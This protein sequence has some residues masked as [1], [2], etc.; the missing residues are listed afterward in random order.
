MAKKLKY[1]DLE[2]EIKAGIIHPVYF[3]VEEESFLKSKAI[4][5]V[6]KSLM[7]RGQEPFN[8]SVFYGEETGAVAVLESLQTPPLGAQKRLAILRNFQNMSPQDKQKIVEYAEHPITSAV[9]I[10]ELGKRLDLSSRIY[11]RLKKVAAT[12][13]FYHP[14]NNTD[15]IRFLQ[16]EAIA[17]QKKLDS[18][19]GKRLVEMVGLDYQKLYTGFQKLLLYVKDRQQITE[20]DVQ[21]C[22]AFSRDYKI[23]DLQ[24]PIGRRD[25]SE[26]INILE[27]LI[28]AG[29]SPVSIII[30]LTQFFKT[31]WKIAILRSQHQQSDSQISSA[32]DNP[33][34]AK[35]L[36]QYA[37]NFSLGDFPA[38]F[39]EL[40][41]ADTLI[42]T[43]TIES[44]IILE[45]MIYRICKKG[46]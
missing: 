16:S 34:N 41:E 17:N 8:L 26:S 45:V 23:F 15:G 18:E 2:H 13:F 11:A 36:L 29:L 46:H 27:S 24:N 3:F 25:I 42:K 40:L 28:V 12:Y 7:S 32:I 1:F 5:L 35:A 44:Q 43:T 10:I 38:I 39:H 30:M 21:K 31:L 20:M 19:A 22:V 9:A 4:E 14:Y 37:Q 33:Y 6:R